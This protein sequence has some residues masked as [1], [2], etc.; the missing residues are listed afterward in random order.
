[1]EH[2]KDEATERKVVHGKAKKP[3]KAPG[4]TRHGDVEEITKALRL[5]GA[6]SED[7]SG[8]PSDRNLKENVAPVDGRDILARLATIPIETWNYKGEA[9]SIRHLGPMA[10][11]FARAF[12]LGADDTRI[13][14]VD[15]SG[16]ALASIQA[17]YEMMSEQK[18]K[19]ADLQREV[20]LLRAELEEVRRAS[21]VTA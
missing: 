13:H 6:K 15:A 3:Y 14:M 19:V 11:D 17:L 21:S 10:Q 16:V 8:I 20:E 1:M 5:A 9:P 2:P 18:G 7:G 12:A 4:L